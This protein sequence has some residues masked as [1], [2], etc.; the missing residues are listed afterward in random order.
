MQGTGKGTIIRTGIRPAEEEH[1]KATV[2]KQRKLPEKAGFSERLL[3]NTAI[4][5]ALLLGILTLKNVD[6]PWSQTAV[7]GIKAA[8]TMR[9]D[10]D[11]TLGELSFVRSFIPESTLVFFN[12]SSSGPLSPV[13]GSIK[14]EYMAGQPWT[15]YSCKAAETVRSALT[16]TV[17]AVSC[18]ESGDWCVLVDHGNGVETVYAYLD[19]P[20]VDA[21]DSVARGEKLGR[22]RGDTV[23]FEYRENGESISPWGADGR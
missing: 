16:G 11:D 12:M 1:K 8:L 3:R 19:K 5:C 20:E 2:I 14:H 15:L 10:P 13:E 22:A 18:M 9:I 6:A 4:A 7:D 23:Y 17:S 21:G